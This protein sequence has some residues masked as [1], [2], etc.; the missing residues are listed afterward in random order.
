MLLQETLQA[1]TYLLMRQEFATFQ[2]R[3]PSYYCFTE[4]II[5]QE[6]QSGVYHQTFGGR[7]SLNREIRELCFLLRR[8][9]EFHVNTL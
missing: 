6:P 7:P 8:E 1:L 2:C 3:F 4:E 5:F 9:I